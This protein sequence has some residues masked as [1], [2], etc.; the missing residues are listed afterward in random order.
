MTQLNGLH[1]SGV[2]VTT[3][4]YACKALASLGTVC[5]NV[6]STKV[7]HRNVCCGNVVVVV[8]VEVVVAVA[9]TAADAAKRSATTTSVT[10]KES[11]T[12]TV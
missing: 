10:V 8:V 5:I 7:I 1:S 9:V 2:V 4:R 11:P 12:R 3:S 6:W